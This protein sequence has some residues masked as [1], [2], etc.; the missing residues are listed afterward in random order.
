MFSTTTILILSARAAPEL[1]DFASITIS[2]LSYTQGHRGA[3]L[4]DPELEVLGPRR[5]T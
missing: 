2:S 4:G 1:D 3:F 5:L